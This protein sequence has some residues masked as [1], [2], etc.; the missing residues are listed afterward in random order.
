MPTTNMARIYYSIL[1]QRPSLETLELPGISVPSNKADCAIAS[2]GELC[3]HISNPSFL[4]SCSGEMVGKM[5]DAVQE[6]H[7]R[8][9]LFKAIGS[10]SQSDVGLLLSHAIEHAFVCKEIRELELDISIAAIANSA[11]YLADPTK[12]TWT[13]LDHRDWDDLGRSINN[14]GEIYGLAVTPADACLSGL[15]ALEDLAAGQIGYLSKLA[16]L[17]KL[18]EL[19]GSFVWT[20]RE[21][22]ARIGDQEVEWFV[23]H[24][25]SL[26]LATFMCAHHDHLHGWQLHE[27]LRSLQVKRPRLEIASPLPPQHQSISTDALSHIMWGGIYMPPPSAVT[28]PPFLGLYRLKACLTSFPSDVRLPDF[29][30]GY[31]SEFHIHRILWLVRLNSATMTCLDL[32][33]LT[34]RNSRVIRDVART[35]TMLCCLKTLRLRTHPDRSLTRQSFDALFFSCPGSLVEFKIAYLISGITSAYKLE[36]VETDWDF[37]Q[38]PLRLRENPLFQLKRLALSAISQ[39]LAPVFCAMLEHCPALEALE[40]PYLGEL[41]DDMMFVLASLGEVCPSLSSLSFPE[42]C[43]PEHIYTILE[44]LPSHRLK[45]FSSRDYRD[46]DPA[47]MMA[48]VARHSTTLQK[49]ELTNCIQ[50][51]SKVMQSV[52]T[53]CEALEVLTVVGGGSERICL[54]FADA[55]E[56]EWVCTRLRQLKIYVW[57]ITNEMSIGFIRDH[58]K[59]SWTEEQHRIWEDLGRLYTQ[60]GSLT[61]LEVL[62]L[63]AVERKSRPIDYDA[64]RV[65]FLPPSETYLP[66]LLALEDSRGTGQQIGYLSRLAGLTRLRELKGSV[67]W[68]QEDAKMRIGEATGA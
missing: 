62:E 67:V 49:I 45:G 11:K 36:P 46:P 66:G 34:L 57:I 7:L 27:H 26:R 59:G 17:I 12:V 40:S 41:T 64:D 47:P 13:A 51:K 37:D 52:L 35:I 18:R 19:R 38:G 6:K 60:I 29:R 53:L 31:N 2:I 65:Y 61:R 33:Q 16:G 30:R 20:N 1:R 42:G 14:P 55:I 28:L 21:T 3:P 39:D 58:S 15:L 56:H 24:L 5:A 54:M 43:R 8:S 9:L 10:G 44:A 22:Q 50:I 25:P 4:H 32:T 23:N 63:R 68:T 48:A